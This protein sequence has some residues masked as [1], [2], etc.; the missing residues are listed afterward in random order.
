MP[1]LKTYNS[2]LSTTK[3]IS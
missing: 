2:F 3:R 1:I